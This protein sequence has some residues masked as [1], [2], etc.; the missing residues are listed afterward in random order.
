MYRTLE[1]LKS[2][3]FLIGLTSP[4]AIAHEGGQWE[5]GGDVALTN[6]GPG[7]PT[8]AMAPVHGILLRNG[9]VVLVDFYTSYPNTNPLFANR[10]DVV[11]FDPA[12]RTVR[13]VWEDSLNTPPAP[14]NHPLY[15]AGHCVLS[16]G[17]VL[18]RGGSKILPGN[19]F[20]TLYDPMLGT[21]GSFVQGP[22]ENWCVYLPNCGFYTNFTKRWYPSCTLMPDGRILMT[23]GW[24]GATVYVDGNANVP[25]I[26]TPNAGA[27]T[28][29]TWEP[30]RNAEYCGTDEPSAENC[31][32]AA[33]HDFNIE[34]YP[35][36]F[37]LSDG[38]VFYARSQYGNPA[39]ALSMKSRKLDPVL[40]QDWVSGF[41]P[42]AP[43][44][45][46]AAVMFGTDTILMTGGATNE[47][48]TGCDDGTQ[49]TAEAYT[50]NPG[51]NGTQTWTAAPSMTHARVN[52]CLVSLPNGC[53]LALGGGNPGLGGNPLEPCDPA[54][55]VMQTEL[56]D[57]YMLGGPGWWN[58]AP[59][60]PGRGRLH[61]YIA[62]LL[63]DGTVLVAGGSA[64][65]D[66]PNA[67]R[68]Y[69]IY[70]P[71][72][73]GP[74]PV[75]VPSSIPSLMQYGRA[76]NITLQTALP[77][78][79]VRLI[80]NGA[81]THSFDQDARM[82]ELEFTQVYSSPPGGGGGIPS[83][84]V[85]VRAPLHAN[86]APPGYYMLFLCTGTDG[87]TPSQKGEFVKIGP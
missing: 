26:L 86:L 47:H 80:R 24:Q 42:T 23:D 15:C 67:E 85:R 1:C 56:Y 68:N 27:P 60:L 9:K 3:V 82:M 28:T 75:I 37:V 73:G 29:W 11:L 65:P 58:M 55:A 46:G 57:P 81:V 14:F 53:V 33:P 41:E 69:D 6:P 30:L 22:A 78:T 4:M 8:G 40:Q 71:A 76:Y 83:P 59:L 87:A 51:P 48:P 36:M 79:K 74:R 45:G 12:D 49:V 62:L 18:F 64:G 72:Y 13:L 32:Q 17:R 66:D 44:M 2:V 16:D 77:I 7:E 61:H 38:S 35:F 84:V 50:I 43:I 34:T 52:H 70:Y 31:N 54:N 19:E 39:D 25:V 10:P 5:V 20:T 63:Q 21:V